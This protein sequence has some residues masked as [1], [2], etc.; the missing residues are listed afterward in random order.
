MLSE[1]IRFHWDQSRGMLSFYQKN[2]E[3]VRYIEETRSK[4]FI[5]DYCIDT[6]KGTLRDR[7]NFSKD[8]LD[9][10]NNPVLTLERLLFPLGILKY[11]HS[12]FGFYCP[13]SWKKEHKLVKCHHHRELVVKFQEKFYFFKNK[14]Y[15]NLFISNK[16]LY[17]ENISFPGSNLPKLVK[18]H[19]AAEQ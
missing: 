16:E 13:V 14:E 5:Q 3:N 8:V 17:T 12:K 2:F 7:M 18:F 11:N 6:I 9:T 1:R 4:Q 19:K 10:E 15:R